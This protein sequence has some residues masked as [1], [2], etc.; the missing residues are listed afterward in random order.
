MSQGSE[1]GSG[2]HPGGRTA[3]PPA[4]EPTARK[5]GEGDASARSALASGEVYALN[6]RFRELQDL[7]IQK[8]R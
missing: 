8:D 2:G 1:R 4:Q 7:P 3:L 6:L 5:R